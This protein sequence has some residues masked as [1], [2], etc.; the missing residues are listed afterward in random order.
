M[1][2]AHGGEFATATL[3]S[4]QRSLVTYAS[5]CLLLHFLAGPLPAAAAVLTAFAL[6]V[7]I[8]AVLAWRVWRTIQRTRTK[9][10]V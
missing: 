5:F 6:V 7:C 2:L 9:V 1:E 10:V 4:G 8:A 3:I